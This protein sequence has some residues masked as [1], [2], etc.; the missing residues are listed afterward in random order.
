MA[1]ARSPWLGVPAGELGAAVMVG[2]TGSSTGL[3]AGGGR[4][5]PGCR[6]TWLIHR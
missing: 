1:L 6:G 2:F 5:A 4:Q 3:A